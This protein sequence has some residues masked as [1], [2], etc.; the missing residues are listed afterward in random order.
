ML[1]VVAVCGFFIFR[2]EIDNTDYSHYQE[3]QQSL[4]NANYASD[5]AYCQAETYLRVEEEKYVVS[6]ILANASQ[7]LKDI[8]ILFV[9]SAK[10]DKDIIYPSLG[11]IDDNHFGLVPSTQTSATDRT[12]YV[13]SFSSNEVVS[14]VLIY[15]AYTL[16]ET[17][18]V[19]YVR[20]ATIL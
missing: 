5:F 11:L 20:L 1:V 17:R 13:L 14:H 3:A 15:F 10:A 4:I 18:V 19:E 8:D 2:K 16:N 7:P 12:S 9:D 6:L